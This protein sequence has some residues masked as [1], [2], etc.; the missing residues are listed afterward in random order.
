[1]IVETDKKDFF[2]NYAEAT[3]VVLTSL[4]CDVNTCKGKVYV[5]DKNRYYIAINYGDGEYIT[6]AEPYNPDLYDSVLNKFSNVAGIDFLYNGYIAKSSYDYKFQGTLNT[7]I[8]T[9]QPFT[10]KLI[11]ESNIELAER[12]DDLYNNSVQSNSGARIAKYIKIL[13][14]IVRNEE[15]KVYFA[16]IDDIPIGHILGYFYPEYLAGAFAQIEIEENYRQKGYGAAFLTE[17]TKDNIKPGY[18][19][20]FTSVSDDNIASRKTAEKA[21]YTIVSSRK[22]KD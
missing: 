10:V 22:G 21:G 14:E 2:K 18:G 5:D 16:Y 7:G 17:V 13:A 3:G 6:V 8:A 15:L 20:Y 1:M 12:Y 19:L 11:N 9:E 4:I